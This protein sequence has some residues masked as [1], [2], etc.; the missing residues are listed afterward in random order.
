[1]STP[2]FATGSGEDEEELCGYGLRVMIRATTRTQ[3][4]HNS[5]NGDEC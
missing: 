4:N 1:M 2:P 5:K 3:Q